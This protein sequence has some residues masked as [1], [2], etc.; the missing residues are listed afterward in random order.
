MVRQAW[1]TPIWA[2]IAPE[3]E[4]SLKLAAKLGFERLNETLYHK[5]N[6]RPDAASLVA[7]SLRRLRRRHHHRMIRR[8]RAAA[9]AGAVDAERTVLRRKTPSYS[10]SCRDCSPGSLEP[11]YHAKPCCPCTAAAGRLQSDPP[12]DSRRRERPRRKIALEQLRS[13][14]GWVHPIEAFALGDRRCP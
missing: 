8:L 12:T 7:T 10:R 5:S 9:R 3:N 13:V 14:F 6:G 11:E 2:I 1:M 4:P